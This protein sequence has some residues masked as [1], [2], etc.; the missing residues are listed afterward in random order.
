MKLG[1]LVT[2]ALLIALGTAP[3]IYVNQLNKGSKTQTFN[4]NPLSNST[5][6]IAN[7]HSVNSKPTGDRDAASGVGRSQAA[8]SLLS[9]RTPFDQLQE[10]GACPGCDLRG[11]NLRGMNLEGANLEG[12][13]LERADLAFARLENAIFRK[14]NLKH[15]NLE[16]ASLGCNFSLKLP[17]NADGNGFSIHTN[18]SGP[19]NSNVDVNVNANKGTTTID[20]YADGNVKECTVLNGAD[21][22]EAKLPDGSVYR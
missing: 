14:A 15:A 11:A 2:I 20:L 7:P 18:S 1:N 17:R 4:S 13:N 3:A 19:G 12:A 6:A 16:G 8:R 21:L 10:T 22:K 5:A 9:D